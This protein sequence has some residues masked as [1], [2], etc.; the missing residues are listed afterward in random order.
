ME[1]CQSGIHV[2]DFIRLIGK[3]LKATHIDDNHGD[4]DSHLVPLF[5]SA[6]WQDIAKALKEIGYENDFSYELSRINVPQSAV[7]SWLRFLHDL[8]EGILQ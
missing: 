5:G 8:A 4:K 2:G 1:E 7:V 6:D 3:R